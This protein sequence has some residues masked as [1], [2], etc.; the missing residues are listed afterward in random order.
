MLSAIE[1]VNLTKYFGGF[2]AVD[3]IAF[4]VREGEIFGFLGPNGAGKTTTQRMLTT[5]LEPSSGKISVF[6]HDLAR[7]AYPVKGQIGLVP[8]ESNVYAELT[9]WE[10]LIFT[11]RLYRMDRA[12]RSARAQ[13]LLETFD[14]WEKRN[15]KVENFSKGMRRRLSIA[16]AVIHR[17]RLLFLDEPTP[18]LDAQS[19]RTIHEMIRKMNA[20]GTTIFLTTHQIEEASLL[21][22]RVAII[23]HGQIAAIDTP[24]R[25]KQAFRRVQSVEVSVEPNGQAHGQALG[26]LPGVTTS[27]KMGDK[28]RLYTE[29]PSSLLPQIMDYANMHGLQLISLNTLGPSLEDVFLE[30]TGQKVGGRRNELQED[31]ARQPN[32]MDPVGGRR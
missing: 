9:G 1:V 3:H 17:P 20:E 21:C 5:L 10:N 26:G 16:M 13:E 12:V 24:E 32:W 4:E 15:L 30:I 27:T 2:L 7:D 22:D 31:Q 14:L 18:G 11:A 23:N 8:E 19:A 6:G 29:D 28:W 25:L